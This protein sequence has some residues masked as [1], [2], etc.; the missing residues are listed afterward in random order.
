[1]TIRWI[2]YTQQN[3]PGNISFALH[4]H[5]SLDDAKDVFRVFCEQVMYDDCSMTLYAVPNSPGLRIDMIAQAKDFADVG[6][7]FDCP[8][9]LIEH[10]PRGGIVVTKN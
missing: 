7:P 8:D 2:S 6:C 5:N 3:I 4:F 9:R 1:V 10:G